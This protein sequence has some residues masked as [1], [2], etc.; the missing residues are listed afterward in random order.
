LGTYS[1]IFMKTTSLLWRHVYV[2][3]SQCS[4]L[5]TLLPLVN[6]HHRELR[7]TEQEA[8]LSQRPRCRVHYSFRQKQKTGTGRQYFT[9]VIGL[10][11]T[12]V[13]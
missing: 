6:K 1:E 10:S 9:D 11:S 13:T 5:L 12:T 7:L 3:V 4:I 2:E 8:Q